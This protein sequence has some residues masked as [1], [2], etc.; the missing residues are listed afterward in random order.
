[1]GVGSPCF[2]GVVGRIYPPE[3]Q[4]GR[5]DTS[6]AEAPFLDLYLSVSDGFVSSKICDKRDGFGLYMVDFPFLDG[7]VPRSTSCGVYISQLVRFAGV[8]G[9]VADFGARDGGLAAGLLQRGYRCRRLRGTF[10]G[11]VADTT[12]CFLNSLLD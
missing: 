2:G 6:G 7:D 12:N 9:C 4:L 5:A 8:S 3:L 1:M 10:S 11:F